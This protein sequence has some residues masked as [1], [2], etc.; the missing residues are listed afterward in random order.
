MYE[1]AFKF[2]R[3]Y[4]AIACVKNL[5]R[6]ADSGQ[7]ALANASLVCKI[8]CRHSTELLYSGLFL[9]SHRAVEL[10]AITV[11]GSPELAALVK[12]V[13]VLEQGASLPVPTFTENSW[14]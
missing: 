2:T 8:W 11:S 12:D 3:Y 7:V 6:H 9:I 1:D 13:Y 4:P 14:L 10:F 5:V